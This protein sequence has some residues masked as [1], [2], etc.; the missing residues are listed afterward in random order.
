[1]FQSNFAPRKSLTARRFLKEL[2][3]RGYRNRLKS[4]LVH[5]SDKTRG[6]TDA[7]KIEA[8]ACFAR[9]AAYPNASLS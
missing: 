9:L 4:D 5:C 8:H 3:A 2:E 7:Q 6:L 1:M